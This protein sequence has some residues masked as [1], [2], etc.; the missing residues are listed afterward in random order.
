QLQG[1]E[2][3]HNYLGKQKNAIPLPATLTIKLSQLISANKEGVQVRLY[4]DHPFKSRKDGGKM[5]EFEREALAW[6]RGKPADWLRDN[7]AEPYYQF[8]DIDERPALRYATAQ[9]MEKACV[10]CHNTHQDSTKKDWKEGEV[11]G[12]L[13]IIRPLDR[14][15]ARARDGLHST[16][17]LMAGISGS[18]LGLTVLVLV[19]RNRRRDPVPALRSQAG[20]EDV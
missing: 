20:R 19:L 10:Q 9:R 18:L 2:V 4:S 15:V 17:V 11:V 14:D 12:V 16:L 5:D 1:L 6:F 3:T 7:P 13:E 8:E